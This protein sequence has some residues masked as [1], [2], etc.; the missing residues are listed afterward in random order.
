M[1]TL[2][3]SDNI[4][5]IGGTGRSGTTILSKIFENHS[6]VTVAPE[7]RFMID[8]DGIID[9]LNCSE[10]WSPYHAD[11]R[12]KRL[13]KVL[14]NVNHDTFWLKIASMVSRKYLEKPLSRKLTRQYQGIIAERYSPNFTLLVKKLI[15]KLYDFSFDGY[16]TGMAFLEKS[17]IYYCHQQSREQL[18][19]IFA[20]FYHSLINDVLASSKADYYL[21]KNTWN[22]LWFDKIIEILPTSRL[23]H[24]YRDPRDVVA[25]Y[26]QQSWMPKDPTASARIYLDL[27]RRWEQVRLSVPSTSIFEI[28][29]EKL[30]DQPESTLKAACEFWEIPWESS[31]LLTDIS[32]SNAGRWKKQFTD[33]EAES[34]SNVLEDLLVRQGYV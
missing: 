15:D 8:P 3:S 19:E 27:F 24:I 23:I 25:S 17:E 13:A 29:L 5:M 7:W 2:K 30:T 32:R 34:V 28:S 1:N 12:L 20:D 31:L 6:R 22:I 14:K 11:L 26:T 18:I 16:W 9:Y 10:F 33:K 21:E 4:L